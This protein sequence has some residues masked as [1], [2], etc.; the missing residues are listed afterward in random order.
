M[1][2]TF[3]A[4][5]RECRAAAGVS[6]TQ[7]AKQVNYSKSYLSKLENDVKPPNAIIAR[8]CDGVLDAGGV[9]IASARAHAGADIDR[10]RVLAGGGALL[11]I[12]LTGGS[13][14][15]PDE[16]VL[17]GLRT[18][19]EQLR[20]LGTHT[21]PTVVLEPLVAH[22]RVV[23][24]LAK[25]SPEPV[26]SRLVLLAARIAEYIGWLCQEAGDDQ[27]ALA[28]TRNATTL[29][30]VGGDR[31]IVSYAY[32]REA[33]IALYQQDPISTIELAQQAGRV[34]RISAR[35]LGLAA[36]REAQGHALAGDG[37]AFE[38]AFDRAAELLDSSTE[39]S[40]LYPVLGSTVPEPLALARGWALVD[41]GRAGEAAAILDRE[42]SR[43]PATA[44][45]AR[46]R[47]GVR[48][49]LAHAVAG[50]LDESCRTLAETIED[51]AYVDSATIRTDLRELSRSLSRWRGHHAVREVF[52][53]LSR[54]LQR[55]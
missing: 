52:P 11:G 31:E 40:R 5:L 54:L 55:Y 27:G 1:A 36:R 29:A 18:S 10:R 28:W 41:L 14:P 37:D 53:E 44:R 3:G 32:V 49:S 2:E 30:Q 39:D 9:L 20:V 17:A 12:A 34:G 47:F 24:A 45:R 13:R 23:H 25:G 15:V 38:R 19:F 22:L 26:R 8:L 33:G 7:L 35:T 6:M 16:R 42:V 46:A 48:R 4:L 50:D 51:A 21:S 43:M